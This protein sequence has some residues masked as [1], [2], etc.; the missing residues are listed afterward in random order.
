MNALARWRETA[1]LSQKEVSKQLGVS[2]SAYCG[3]EN[4]TQPQIHYALAIEK[5]TDGSV[6]VTAWKR[7]KKVKQ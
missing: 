7:K 5:L 6:P 1:G 3:W 2:Q 4:G